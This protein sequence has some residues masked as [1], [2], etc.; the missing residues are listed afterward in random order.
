MPA[1]TK[2]NADASAEWPE[3]PIVQGEPLQAIRSVERVLTRPDGTQVVVLVP[4]YPCFRLET[5]PPSASE[6]RHLGA[7]PRRAARAAGVEET[8]ADFDSEEHTA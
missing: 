3:A 2:P 5:W 4:V 8:D 7:R 6:S 1:R